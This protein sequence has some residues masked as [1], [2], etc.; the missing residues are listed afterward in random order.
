MAKEHS[1]AMIMALRL[2]VILARFSGYHTTNALSTE[3]VAITQADVH[4]ET[5]RANPKNLHQKL[6]SVKR[7]KE[8]A[9]FVM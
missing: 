8:A 6:D 2:V 4:S 5:C 1:T 9:P 7:L 3:N